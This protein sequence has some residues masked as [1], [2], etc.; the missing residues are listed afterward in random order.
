MEEIASGEAKSVLEEREK[1]HNLSHI[2]CRNV[3]SSSGMP[4]QHDAIGEKVIRSKFADFA[5][6]CNGRLKNLWVRDSQA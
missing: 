4:L 6:I 2:G 3:F 5:F 1:H